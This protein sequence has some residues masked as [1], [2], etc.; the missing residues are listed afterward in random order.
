MSGCV[1]IT[2]VCALGMTVCVCVRE[3]ER[4]RER[5][6][7]GGWCWRGSALSRWDRGMIRILVNI[8]KRGGLFSSLLNLE[9]GWGLERG[10]SGRM[11]LGEETPPG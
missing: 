4:E 11:G 1:H 5:E 2:H 3:K 6:R 7:D 8:G 10:W 9:R